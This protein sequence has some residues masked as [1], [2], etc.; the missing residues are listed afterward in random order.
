MY[1][2]I[3]WHR[4]ATTHDAGNERRKYPLI[5]VQIDTGHIVPIISEGLCAGK[6]P[7][8]NNVADKLYG[9]CIKNN[10]HTHRMASSR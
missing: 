2:I 1:L 5:T 6:C 8:C 10:K 9:G 4:S 7:D 3:S